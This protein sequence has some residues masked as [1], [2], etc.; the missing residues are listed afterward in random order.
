[1]SKSIVL[2]VLR[3]REVV[4]VRAI[5]LLSMMNSLH[6]EPCELRDSHLKPLRDAVDDWNPSLVEIDKMKLRL[7]LR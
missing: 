1:M 4:A 6:L 3:K 7:G 5:E 2:A